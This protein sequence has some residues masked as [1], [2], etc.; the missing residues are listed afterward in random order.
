MTER[1]ESGRYTKRVRSFRGAAATLIFVSASTLCA[2]VI[3]IFH[4]DPATSRAF[5][6]YVAAYEKAD[7]ASFSTS[8]KLWVDRQCCNCCGKAFGFD[9]GKPIVEPRKNEDVAKGSIHHFSGSIRV[10]GA[11]IGMA[12]QVMQDYPNY[13]RYFKGDLGSA[14]AEKQGDFR[15]EDEHYVTNLLLVQTTLWISVTYDSTYDVHYYRLDKNR[16]IAR[17]SSKSIRE[18]RDPRNAA[19]G[20]F[21]EGDDHGFLLRTNTYWYLRERDGGLDMQV[22]SMSLSR[23]S[24]TGFGWWGT[25]RTRDAVDKM[26]RDTKAAIENVK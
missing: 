11:T 13:V 17:S 5:D 9:E 12:R 23:P 4:L 15:P 7:Y 22:D 18:Q 19:A 3:P 25:R 26:L 16:M 21:P 20:L 24:P 10:K 6:D 1:I 2:A 14:R 8:G